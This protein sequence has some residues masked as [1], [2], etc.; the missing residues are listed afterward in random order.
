MVVPA[1]AASSL[2]PP[3]L[4]PQPAINRVD[5]MTMTA[6]GFCDGIFMVF[7]LWFYIYGVDQASARSGRFS[8]FTMLQ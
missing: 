3:L 2:P 5:I 4:P 8:V 6:S 7:L 1:A